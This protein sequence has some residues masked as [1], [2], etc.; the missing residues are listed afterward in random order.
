MLHCIDHVD[1]AATNVTDGTYYSADGTVQHGDSTIDSCYSAKACIGKGFRF[2]GASEIRL[3]ATMTE[4][5]ELNYTYSCWFRL[6][7]PGNHQSNLIMSSNWKSRLH[8]GQGYFDSKVFYHIN[9]SEGPIFYLADGQEKAARAN[10]WHLAAVTVNQT[11]ADKYIKLYVDGVL[12]QQTDFTAGTA[13]G[14]GGGYLTG[15]G[16]VT[17]FNGYIDQVEIV[18]VTRSADW[19]KLAFESQRDRGARLVTI[20]DTATVAARNPFSTRA[21][22]NGTIAMQQNNGCL[23]LSLPQNMQQAGNA[24][25]INAAGREIARATIAAKAKNAAIDISG[26]PAGLYLITVKSAN[27]TISMPYVISR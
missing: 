19:Q 3:P 5:S 1:S 9:Y 16:H 6:R 12:E 26:L 15:G 22:L 2:H 13:Q 14:A 23:T 17:K 27:A 25:V 24:A 20:V 8:I 21:F 4:G 10:R 11:S 7:T 18:N